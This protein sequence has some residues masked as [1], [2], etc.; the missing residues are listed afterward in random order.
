MKNK[1][2]IIALSVVAAVIVA[3]LSAVMIIVSQQTESGDKNLTVTIVYADQ[4]EKKVEI[5][6]DAE[7]LADA[8]LEEKLIKEDEYKTGFYTYID[9]VRAD[10][11]LDGGWWGVYEDGA[12]SDY[13]MNE[14]AIKDGDEFEIKYTPA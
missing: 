10:Y 12:L 8:L 7:Y 3:A 4:T 1:K 14:I 6:T 11:T 5:S 2:L 13:G 9:G